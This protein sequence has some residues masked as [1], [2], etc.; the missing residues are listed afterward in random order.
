MASNEA[1]AYSLGFGYMPCH[2][3]PR[4]PPMPG[5][6]AGCGNPRGFIWPPI[7]PHAE[8]L[9]FADMPFHTFPRAPLGIP[10]SIPRRIPLYIARCVPQ[11]NPCS[12]PF[13]FVWVFIQTF[14]D[15]HGALLRNISANIGR[16]RISQGEV[17]KELSAGS[18]EEADA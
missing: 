14:R 2:T 9:G 1:H 10:R 7:K 8:S 13:V 3:C 15:R 17:K 18:L 5:E 16:R 11:D 12:F 6:D 4:V